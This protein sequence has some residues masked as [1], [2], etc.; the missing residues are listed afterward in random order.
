MPLSA[1]TLIHF[2]AEKEALKGILLDNFRV[3]NC[4]EAISF[5]GGLFCFV[6]PMVS[7]CD[8]PLSE[9][10][11]HISKYG[12]YG[13]GLSK[14]WGVR[15]QLN[16]VLYLSK[17]SH[18]ANS[19]KRAFLTFADRKGSKEWTEEQKSFVDLMRYMKNYEGDLNRSGT[20]TPSYRF[21]DE[22]EW[23]YVPPYDSDCEMISLASK[24]DQAKVKE[25]IDARLASHRLHFEPNDIKYIII[26]DDTEILEFV[27]H[28]R[29]SKGR[30]YTFE[31]IER[32]K[33]RILTTEQI[34]NDI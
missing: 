33:T 4:R 14:E 5:T 26:K 31:D 24:Y 13:L 20:T 29:R 8:I 10:K 18:L 22:R 23:R 3:F 12:S 25:A 6:V 19:Y 2:T 15:N 28:L 34:L 27:D 9:I 17:D 7:F 32:L 21:S 1:S 11:T 16:P 30:K